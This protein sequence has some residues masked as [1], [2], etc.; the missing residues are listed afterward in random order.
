MSA[1]SKRASL[2]ISAS[3][4]VIIFTTL[5]S[6]HSNKLSNATFDAGRRYF[7]LE[8]IATILFVMRLSISS[9]RY[10]VVG[11]WKLNSK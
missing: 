4:L 6:N 9:R 3:R 10:L 8:I 5:A 11:Q 7:T 2:E 1:V